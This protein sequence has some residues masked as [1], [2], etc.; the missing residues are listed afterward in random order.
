VQNQELILSEKL[1]DRLSDRDCGIDCV[2]LSGSEKACLISRLYLQHNRP[3][4]ERLIG[5][6]RFFAGQNDLPISFFP[7]YNI[8]PFKFLSYHSETAG[9]RIRVLHQLMEADIPPIV[10]T[11]VDALLQKIIPR[12][13]IGRYQKII[14]RQE[15]GRYAELLIVEEEIDRDGLIAKLIS[16]GYSKTAIVEEFGDFSV[17]GG[18]LDVFS[19]LYDDPLRIEL[20]GDLVESLRFFSASNQ[21]KIKDV[22]EA[23]ILPARE[24]ILNKKYIPNIISRI[25]SLANEL[26]VPVSHA[27]KIIDTIRHDEDVPGLESLISLFYPQLDTLFDYVMKKNFA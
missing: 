5:D 14:P 13:E 24:L 20:Y 16:G 23:I 15:I 11:T 1:F 26:D 25:R 22:Q 12:Q 9:H 3:E 6:L 21:R 17:R 2:G 8:L 27:R 19:P 18:I 7:P 10:V 4:G